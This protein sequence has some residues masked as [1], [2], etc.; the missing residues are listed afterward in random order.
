MQCAVLLL[1]LRR[2]P[3]RKTPARGTPWAGATA[4]VF[5]RAPSATT[6]TVWPGARLP[7]VLH[8]QPDDQGPDLGDAVA[9]KPVCDVDLP[10]RRRGAPRRRRRRRLLGRG[11]LHDSSPDRAASN[12]GRGRRRVR[13]SRRHPRSP[14]SGDPSTALS[15][16]FA[17]FS[18]STAFVGGCNCCHTSCPAKT[19]GQWLLGLVFRPARVADQPHPHHVA[20]PVLLR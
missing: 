2:A 4:E 14:A 9:V 1:R 12:G 7:V 16:F 13:A 6:T 5:S 3:K 15:S 11:H 18:S 8:R 19:L 17:S 20:G 10:A